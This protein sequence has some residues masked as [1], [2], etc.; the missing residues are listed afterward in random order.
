MISVGYTEPYKK[1][2][3]INVLYRCNGKLLQ[4]TI[5]ICKRKCPKLLSLISAIYC[6][7]IFITE[8]MRICV[9]LWDTLWL[10]RYCAQRTTGVEGPRLKTA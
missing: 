4:Q 5:R 2:L 6:A 7:V 10:S 3:C 8:L 1:L 9:Q